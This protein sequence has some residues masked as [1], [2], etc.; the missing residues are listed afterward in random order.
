MELALAQR[1]NHMLWG[2]TLAGLVYSGWLQFLGTFTSGDQAGGI[3]GV[4]LGFY[5]SPHPLAFIV[6]LLFFR[7]YS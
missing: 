2:L 1:E 6:D 7:R 3:V 5:L 4:V